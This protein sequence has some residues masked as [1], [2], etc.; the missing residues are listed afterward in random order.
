MN[1]KL[2]ILLALFVLAAILSCIVPGLPR[3]T[4]AP[5]LTLTPDSRLPNMVEDMVAAALTQTVQALPLIPSPTL[6]P[7]STFTPTPTMPPSIGSSL[8]AQENGATLFVDERLGYKVVI[9][10]GWLAVRIN[11]QEYFDALKLPETSDPA[12]QSA[13]AWVKNGDPVKLRL[14]VLDMHREHIKDENITSIQFI[15]DDKQVINFNSEAE[16]Q[17]VAD[18]LAKQVTGLK[19]T[20]VEV[21]ITH[22]RMQFGVIESE[23]KSISTATLRQKRVFFKTGSGT[24]TALL[25]TVKELTAEVIPAFDALMD[26][27]SLVQN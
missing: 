9:P 23:T 22:T 3:A 10:Q 4:L 1:N 21:M 5:T 20:S 2:S 18:E 11:E 8:T 13:L 17:A 24:V 26:T 15:W 14:F 6:I 12:L 19:V 25:T 27:V 7:E 16:I